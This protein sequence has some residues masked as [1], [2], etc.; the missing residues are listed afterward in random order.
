MLDTLGCALHGSTLPW[1]RIAHGLVVAESQ[2][3]LGVADSHAAGLM[4]AQRGAM[5]K[6]LHSGHAAQSGVLSALLAREGFTG[7]EDVLEVE[8]GGFCGTMGGG[9]VDLGRLVE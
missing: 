1:S 7:T 8:F 5:V 2:H 3:A 4:C 9:D 6:R